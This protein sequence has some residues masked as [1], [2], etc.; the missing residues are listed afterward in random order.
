MVAFIAPEMT[1]HRVL[2]ELARVQKV[3]GVKECLEAAHPLHARTMLFGHEATLHET[4]AMLTRSRPFPCKRLANQPLR[5]R[6]HTLVVL[7]LR[8]NNGVE[9]SITHMAENTSLDVHFCQELLGIR[10]QLW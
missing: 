1:T 3:I 4:Y 9:V 5:K 6:L 2:D 8:R 7:G 10:D